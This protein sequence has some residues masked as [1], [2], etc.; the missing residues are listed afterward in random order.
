MAAT[1]GLSAITTGRNVVTIYSAKRLFLKFADTF[2]GVICGTGGPYELFEKNLL[3]QR[4]LPVAMAG[5]GLTDGISVSTL[6]APLAVY[7]ALLVL[8]TGLR[9]YCVPDTSAPSRS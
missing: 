3:K 6:W 8:K 2:Q 1:E 9:A 7:V 4:D 5:A